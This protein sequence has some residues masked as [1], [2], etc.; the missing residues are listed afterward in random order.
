MTD[1][2]P[3]LH[4]EIGETVYETRSSRKFSARRPYI[5]PDPRKVLCAIPGVVLKIHA[6][7]G[8]RVVRGEPLLVL[9]AMK[10]EN[11]ILAP[12]DGRIK[13]VHVRQGQMTTKG[14]LLV[15]M[16]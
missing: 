14:A 6:G 5:P 12:H 16:E 11:T 7:P 15:E 8:K 2:E 13:A 10:M 1:D 3:V 9:E 4:L